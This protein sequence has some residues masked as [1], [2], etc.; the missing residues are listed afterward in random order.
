M[1]IKCSFL[2]NHT[3][4][5]IWTYS[6]LSHITG[7]LQDITCLLSVSSWRHTN[8]YYHLQLSDAIL[9]IEN[10]QKVSWKWTVSGRCRAMTWGLRCEWAQSCLGSSWRTHAKR[11]DRHVSGAVFR[12]LSRGT[13]GRSWSC[14]RARRVSTL[15]LRIE[16]GRKWRSALTGSKHFSHLQ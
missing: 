1:N 9:F 11:R 4:Y 16:K 3:R 14:C 7:M 12:G 15:W 2:T 5:L 13:S 8:T 10:T 6:E